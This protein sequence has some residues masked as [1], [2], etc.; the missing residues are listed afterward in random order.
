M[1]AREVRESLSRGS[2][3]QIDNLKDEKKSARAE[4]RIFQ[5]KGKC[6]HEPDLRYLGYSKEQHP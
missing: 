4:G 5:G 6:V 1:F 3:I 2:S